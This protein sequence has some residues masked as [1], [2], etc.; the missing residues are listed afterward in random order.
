MAKF[1]NTEIG[2]KPSDSSGICK[3]DT[4]TATTVARNAISAISPIIYDPFTG[5]ISFNPS[6][7]SSLGAI[8]SGVWNAATI[9]IEYGGTGATT[10]PAAL[11]NLL[12][13]QT[14][15]NLA[16]L[17]TDGTDVSWSLDYINDTTD[18]T[19]TRSGGGPYTLGINLDNANIWVGEQTFDLALFNSVDISNSLFIPKK[20]E[21]GGP[22]EDPED[23]G[24]ICA[25]SD[26]TNIPSIYASLPPTSGGD[27]PIE[28][29]RLVDQRQLDATEME[30]V[31]YTGATGNVD[32]GNKSITTSS[33]GDFGDIFLSGV[34]LFDTENTWVPQT[35]EGVAGGNALLTMITNSTRSAP[36]F[37]EFYVD[38]SPAQYQG[39]ITSSIDGARLTIGDIYGTNP[40]S[41]ALRAAKGADGVDGAA[42]MLYGGA[43]GGG[44]GTTGGDLGLYAGSGRQNY[45][46][47][48]GTVYLYSGDGKGASGSGD[49]NIDVGS[50]DRSGS[51][52]S[53]NIGGKASAVDV[54][55]PIITDWIITSTISRGAPLSVVSSDLVTNLNA[56]M[57]DG[58]HAADIIT[59]PGGNT[60]E[61]QFNKSGSFAGVG[62]SSVDGLY[63][64]SFP[65]NVTARGTFASVASGAPTLGL[66]DNG[67]QIERSGIMPILHP[68]SNGDGFYS[69]WTCADELESKL[70]NYTCSLAKPVLRTYYVE[71]PN[72][73]PREEYVNSYSLTG[74]WGHLSNVGY[75]YNG[76]QIDTIFESGNV[77]TIPTRTSSFKVIMEDT[78]DRHKTAVCRTDAS[79]KWTEV[80]SS[81]YATDGAGKYSLFEVGVHPSGANIGSY[82]SAGASF[83]LDMSAHSGYSLLR[84]QD[85]PLFIGDIRHGVT[86]SFDGV[87]G[88]ISTDSGDIILDPGSGVTSADSIIVN[89]LDVQN[90]NIKNVADPLVD[91]DAA[92]KKYVDAKI[93]V[94]FWEVV[95]G[96]GPI[97]LTVNVGYV[98]RGT[99][100][101]TVVLT[102]PTATAVGDTIGIVSDS[103]TDLYQVSQT[104]S[105]QIRFG[106][107]E[108]TLGSSGSITSSQPGDKLKLLAID[109]SGSR[110][111]VIDSIGSFTI[112]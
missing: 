6:S 85:I 82:T 112:S 73:G 96:A 8:T 4:S 74:R 75:S 21:V 34:S 90:H 89:S 57:V 32:L 10:A 26:G 83:S 27:T 48:G 22:S 66:I 78:I 86:I 12:P 76:V 5:V 45:D 44:D 70:Y 58:L 46:S 110:W 104:P 33:T 94:S 61:L 100:G 63:N 16:V 103:T 93:G 69:V 99:S 87:N 53:I 52:G 13:N 50:V 14:D 1:I 91:Y 88:N 7:I 81:W 109:Y 62:G 36:A 18:T 17:M 95:A 68:T 24:Q 47:S 77:H 41:L 59:S 43:A 15:N 65:A 30:Y 11:N 49:I 101:G 29:V 19:L 102:L 67:I 31:P 72:G 54:K 111:V 28:W 25:W 20:T 35:I 42:A 51:P 105:Q 23:W 71:G 9:G 39:G 64:V 56:D 98:L 3:E 107:A 106:N 108:T 79:E 38:G 40:G 55:S 97:A 37:I 2:G 80:S 84:L 60:D 92:N